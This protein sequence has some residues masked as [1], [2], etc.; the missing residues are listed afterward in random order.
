MWLTIGHSKAV[1]AL[2]RGLDAGRTSHAYLFTG[3]HNVG[4]MTLAVDLARAL[5]CLGDDKPCGECGQCR[6]IARGIHPDVRVVGLDTD[7]G[8]SRVAIGIDQVREVQREAGLTPYEGSHRV[9]IFDGVEYMSEEAAN[10][11]LKTLEE[12]PDQ[13]VLLLLTSDDATLPPTLVSRC[14]LLDLRPVA[15]SLIAQ[16]LVSRLGTDAAAADEI[17]RLSGGRPGW[18]MDAAARPD[19]L[20]RLKKRLEVMEGVVRGGVEVRFAYAADL[21]AS[22]AR[23]RDRVRQEL[24]SWLALWRDVLL[25]KEGV[26]GLVV[27]TSM[28]ETLRS[29]A[30]SLSLAQVASAVNSVWQ[31]SDHLERNVNPRLALEDLMLGLPRP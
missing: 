25:A 31:A 3:P 4:K 30:T 1:S 29:L 8:R 23:D 22:F 2:R 9:F 18:A 12:P 21:A 28:M 7:A 5:N 6:R 20:E 13:V 15:S 16:E 17:A 19:V 24:T 27:H 11:L 14:Q 26:P 10:S